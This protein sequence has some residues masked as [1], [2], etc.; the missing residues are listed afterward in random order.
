M[1][2][3]MLCGDKKVTTIYLVIT[4]C[5]DPIVLPTVPVFGV[6][7]S[8]PGL[9]GLEILIALLA[10]V[11]IGVLYIVL[12]QIIITPKVEIAVVAG[13]MKFGILVLLE[14]TIVRKPTF[15]LVTVCNHDCGE[16]KKGS[17]GSCATVGFRVGR[18]QELKSHL[19]KIAR[20]RRTL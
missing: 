6:H 19:C 14:G 1:K 15:A 18:H 13:P 16:L 2:T 20:S 10:I 3:Y 11:V 17:V 4:R 7:M 8:P 9:L 12:P 5:T